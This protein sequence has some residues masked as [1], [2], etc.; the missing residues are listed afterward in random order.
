LETRRRPQE[1]I[2]YS[3]QIQKTIE[4]ATI[5]GKAKNTIR[6]FRQRLTQLS[7]VSDLMNPEDVKKAIA[8]SKVENSTKCSYV[9][10]YEWFCKTHGLTWQKPK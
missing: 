6:N 2:R 1:D 4:K 3:E 10:A 7:R 5:E 9:L 8:Y